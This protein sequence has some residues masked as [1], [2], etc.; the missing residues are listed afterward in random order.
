[1]DASPPPPADREIDQYPSRIHLWLIAAL[2]ALPPAMDPFQRSLHEVLSEA[3]VTHK[4]VGSPNQR[5]PAR[6][7]E[8]SELVHARL[9]HETSGRLTLTE[10]RTAGKGCE[11]FS[12][13]PVA[14]ATRLPLEASTEADQAAVAARP[15]AGQLP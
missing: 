2:D 10:P 12:T 1:V 6:R 3:V 4:Q 8:L 15:A 13:K 9:I 14:P 5:L 11:H 7:H